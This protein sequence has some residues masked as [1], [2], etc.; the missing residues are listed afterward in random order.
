MHAET[1]LRFVPLV[2]LG[3][4][5]FGV[6]PSWL[7]MQAIGLVGFGAFA[8]ATVAGHL[9]QSLGLIGSLRVALVLL[10]ALDL[11]VL[12]HEIGHVIAARLAGLSV[13]AVVLMPYG[14][15][16]IRSSS[17]SATVARWTAAGGPLANLLA[18]SVC[19]LLFLMVDPHSAAGGGLVIAG[20]FQAISAVTN[21]VPIAHLDGARIFS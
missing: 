7:P 14:G 3:S 17:Q 15:A 10:A 9:G 12:A 6:A 8:Y 19:G 21:L 13:R 11:T 16:T 2:R 4:T 20:A 1:S 18:A 5:S